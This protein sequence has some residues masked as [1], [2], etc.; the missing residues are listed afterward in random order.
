M[1]T[2][3]YLALFALATR[4]FATTQQ[5]LQ[6]QTFDEGVRTTAL[7]CCNALE[8]ILTSSTI[9][10]P[11]S[12]KYSAQS[13]TYYSLE[14]A[15]QKPACRI[16]P[17]TTE[18]L[19]RLIKFATATRCE[20]AV[21]AGGHMSWEGSSNIGPNGFTIDLGGLKE[22]ELKDDGKTV[23]IAPGLKWSEVYGFLKPHGLHTVGG[24]SSGVG[25][26]GFLIGGGVSFLSTEM[27]LGSDNVL[28]YEVVLADGSIVHAN[29]SERS[30][31]YW[32]LKS[33]STNYGIVTRFLMPTIPRPQIWGGSL[34]YHGSA[35]PRLFKQ[36]ATFTD[37]LK[38]DPHGMSAISVAWSPEMKDYA[39][40]S[41]NVY[42]APQAYPSPLFDGL[43]DI[44]PFQSTM[45]VADLGEITDEV[46]MLSPGGR[47]SQWFSVVF[48]NDAELPWDIQ[49]KGREIFE[50]YH[51]RPGAAWA[52]TVQ[53]INEG[54]IA[55]GHKRG[56]NPLGLSVEDGDQLLL[57][58]CVFWND[59]QDSA[60]MKA[61]AQ[62]YIKAATELARE[63]GL[64][65]KYIYLNYALDTQNVLESYGAENLK[66]M[67]EIKSKY[68]PDNL[69]EV[70]KGGWKL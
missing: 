67:R 11:A 13:S 55:A 45:R 14:Q 50:P 49:L 60:V 70:W 36:L 24:R 52:I 66:K 65:N 1:H 5:P 12:S 51:D 23:S 3:A 8:D 18:D 63:R 58:G 22:V 68:D 59:P 15:A 32:A 9:L 2:G 31:L 26:G 46:D 21:R 62:E 48:K 33:G 4:S 42:L 35:G 53:P 41:P 16:A 37:R 40:W 19:S 69:L 38:E 7:Q 47:N 61:K 54:M 56:G 30:D 57:L 29:E 6:T 28:D 17:A 20:F 25:V 39:I 43:Q 64:L 34:F 44:E 27:G 10:Y